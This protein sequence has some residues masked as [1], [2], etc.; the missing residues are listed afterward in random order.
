MLKKEMTRE[1]MFDALEQDYDG[2]MNLGDIYG[3]RGVEAAMDTLHLYEKAL[4]LA[5][6]E[7]Q[8]SRAKKFTDTKSTPEIFDE[9]I[10]YAKTTN[11]GEDSEH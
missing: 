6:E 4:A 11:Y 8:K 1:A 10:A 9:Y 2:L 5:C 3:A 7:I